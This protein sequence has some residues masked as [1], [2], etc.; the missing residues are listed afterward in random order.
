[1]NGLVKRHWIWSVRFLILVLS[2]YLIFNS[3]NIFKSNLTLTGET[4]N[5]DLQGINC[6]SIT[7]ASPTIRVNGADG[8][9]MFPRNL[10]D[11]LLSVYTETPPI[12]LDNRIW[13]STGWTYSSSYIPSKNFI[14]AALDFE[15]YSLDAPNIKLAFGGDV[16]VDDSDNLN[17]VKNSPYPLT[18]A[19][20]DSRNPPFWSRSYYGA[21]GL[22]KAGQEIITFN[23]GENKNYMIS[24]SSNALCYQSTLFDTPMC[25]ACHAGGGSSGD[26]LEAY[27]A[28]IGM[29]HTISSSGVG[30]V[31][32][33]PIL[34]P[35]TGYSSYNGVEA[36]G[37][38]V[39]HP[40]SIIFGDYIYIFYQDFSIG[41]ASEGRSAGMKV[42]RAPLSGAGRPGTW[43]TWY[44]INGVEGWDNA[45]P[46]T[47]NTNTHTISNYAANGGRA[48]NI[49]YDTKFIND[50]NNWPNACNIVNAKI[51]R[52]SSFAVA[53]IRNTDYYLGVEDGAGYAPSYSYW[54]AL[55]LSKDL[56]HWS[57]AY[58]IEESLVS[59]WRNQKLTFARFLSADFST[60]KEID[61]GGFYIIGIHPNGDN[62]NP[63]D[64]WRRRQLNY[65]FVKISLPST[66][67]NPNQTYQ[68]CVFNYSNWSLCY[69]S[70]TRTRSITSSSP[71]GCTDGSPNLIE[72][73][74]HTSSINP[75]NNLTEDSNDGDALPLPVDNNDSIDNLINF[76]FQNNTSDASNDPA[77][78]DN[79]PRS[80]A[81]KTFFVRFFCKIAHLLSN[82]NY[83]SCVYRHLS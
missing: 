51:H 34:W 13:F 1:M 35:A 21:F 26:C 66:I 5:T 22:E 32:E 77:A 67:S 71:A 19:E 15:S 45:L 42:A 9:S 54:I 41:S 48:S 17:P 20:L 73:C 39:R 6:I 10:G 16:F 83:Q 43:R 60:N 49:F 68:T 27:S 64:S 7:E 65:K 25:S 50:Y 70:D 56:I 61:A 47:Y 11:N 28:F 52:A 58:I 81:I 29:A 36:T 57:D 24:E 63:Q 82:D 31:D 37:W 53:K 30:F 74:N 4:I 40:N 75:D 69:Q 62:Q 33:G 59:D 18:E 78:T 76:S 46:S 80:G 23:P 38:G 3:F 79:P 55:R 8:N 14:T 2:I 72:Q 44:K 12:I